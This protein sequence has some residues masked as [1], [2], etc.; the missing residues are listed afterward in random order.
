MNSYSGQL[1]GGMATLRV[2]QPM[3]REQPQQTPSSLESKPHMADEDGKEDQWLNQCRLRLAASGLAW[4]GISAATRHGKAHGNQRSSEC[5][6]MAIA[7][8]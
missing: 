5:N 7:N 4:N 6:S 3:T 1:L 2:R 8:M